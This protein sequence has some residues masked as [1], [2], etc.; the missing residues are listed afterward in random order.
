MND[1]LL[2]QITCPECGKKDELKVPKK[3][4]KDDEFKPAKIYI[5]KGIICKHSFIVHVSP[6][7]IIIGYGKINLDIYNEEE[8]R[9]NI[10]KSYDKFN[11]RLVVNLYGFYGFI[12][13][14]H[15]KLNGYP[16]YIINYKGIKIDI[17]AFNSFFDNFIPK[18]INKISRIDF[19]DETNYKSISSSG[20][21]LL[22]INARNNSMQ[23]SWDSKLKF[24]EKLFKSAFKLKGEMTRINFIKKKLESVLDKIELIGHQIKKLENKYSVK[25]INKIISSEYGKIKKYK[26]EFIKELVFNQIMI[27]NK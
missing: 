18:K 19:L 25:E 2:I 14:V 23:A 7:G 10:E 6:Q 22:L 26:V 20:D 21:R 3:L 12:N 16:I 11:L 9:T 8:S 1:Y 5:S 24:E 17:Y 27:N 15:A 13:I 4:F